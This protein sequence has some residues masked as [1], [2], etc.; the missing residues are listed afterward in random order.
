M[1]KLIVYIF[2]KLLKLFISVCAQLFN[3]SKGHFLSVVVDDTSEIK[4]VMPEVLD[5]IVPPELAN[6]PGIPEVFLLRF[7]CFRLGQK[8]VTFVYSTYCLRG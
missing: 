7:I 4:I 3:E 2:K 5:G 6:H 8:M 1:G